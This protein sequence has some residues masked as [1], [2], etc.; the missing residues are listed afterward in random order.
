MAVAIICY[1]W[2]ASFPE[3]SRFL[4]AEYKDLYIARLERDHGNSA[5]EPIPW[6]VLRETRTDWTI[7]M[8]W[9]LFTLRKSSTHALPSFVPSSLTVSITAATFGLVLMNR[10]WVI[11]D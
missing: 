8:T 3:E 4:K 5:T 7:W 10:A 11:L 9:L 6:K 2:L 1:F